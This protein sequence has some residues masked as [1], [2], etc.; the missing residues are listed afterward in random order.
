MDYSLIVAQNDEQGSNY[1]GHG[2]PQNLENVSLT[3][4]PSIGF[5]RQPFRNR[6]SAPIL[7]SRSKI[8]ANRWVRNPMEYDQVRLLQHL[9]FSRL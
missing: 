8:E 9:I 2:K 5:D 6:I 7:T 1:G 4:L 3:Q